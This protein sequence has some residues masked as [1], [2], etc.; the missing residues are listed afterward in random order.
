MSYLVENLPFPIE[1]TLNGNA[2]QIFAVHHVKDNYLMFSCILKDGSVFSKIPFNR[3]GRTFQPLYKSQPWPAEDSNFEIIFHP[4]LEELEDNKLKYY[5]TIHQAK[6]KGGD[7]GINTFHLIYD[8]GLDFFMVL[9]NHY[10]KFHHGRW[11]EENAVIN[12]IGTL[13]YE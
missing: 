8:T 12:K 11:T 13:T 10:C 1:S 4:M 7:L 6:I 2:C 3:F 9:P 5:F